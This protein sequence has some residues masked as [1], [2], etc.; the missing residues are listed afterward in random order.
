MREGEGKTNKGWKGAGKECMERQRN[1]VGVG[2]D[3]EGVGRGEMGA[4]NSDK[5]Q[6]GV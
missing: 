4:S 3:T 2:K 6:T 1:R 5:R